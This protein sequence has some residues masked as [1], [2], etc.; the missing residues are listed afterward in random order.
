MSN[1]HNKDQYIYTVLSYIMAASNL[2]NKD[3]FEKTIRLGLSNL[4]EEK[5]M[6]LADVYRREG[7]REGRQ[8]GLRQ[9]LKTVAKNLL[10]KGLPL[11]E[12]RQITNLSKKEIEKL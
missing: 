7:K 5:I 10:K 9:G 4:D 2:S 6:T 11:N 3:Q 1:Q 12:I 8:E